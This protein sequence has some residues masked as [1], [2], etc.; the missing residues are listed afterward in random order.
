VEE[1]EENSELI[2]TLDF[3]ETSM[4][5][6]PERRLFDYIKRTFRFG[7]RRLVAA[8]VSI[9]RDRSYVQEPEPAKC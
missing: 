6:L 5:E 9:R 4:L 8:I 7:V 1:R 3:V 2:V